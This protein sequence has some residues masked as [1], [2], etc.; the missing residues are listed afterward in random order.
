[1]TDRAAHDRPRRRTLAVRRA[2]RRCDEG[3]PV[4]RKRCSVDGERG[5]GTVEY[6]GLLIAIGALLLA[7]MTQLK[8][9]GVAKEVSNAM[10]A[11]IRQV[12]GQHSA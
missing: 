7:V 12:I 1:V 4:V 9:G 3:V 2:V 5:Q 10:I 8:G 11:A 6:L